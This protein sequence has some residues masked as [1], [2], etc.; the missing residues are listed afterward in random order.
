MLARSGKQARAAGSSQP[1]ITS[2]VRSDPVAAARSASRCRVHLCGQNGPD[3]VACLASVSTVDAVARPQALADPAGAGRPVRD[4]RFHDFRHDI[5]TKVLRE[6]GNLK[7]AQRALNHASPYLT[8][9]RYAHVLDG[10][11]RDA[12]SNAC[13]SP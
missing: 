10:E 1:Q 8:T 6:T 5:G 11:V 9:L 2:E 13:K 7:I 4:F 12:C 3:A